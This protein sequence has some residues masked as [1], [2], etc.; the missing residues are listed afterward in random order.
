MINLEIPLEQDRHF[1]YRLFEILPGAL[2][3]LLLLMPFILS[4]INVSLAVIF[5]VAYLLIYFVR[6]LGIDIRAL[7]GY[8][9]MKQHQRLVW[10]QLLVELESG[11]I[12]EKVAIERPKWHFNNVSRLVINPTPVKP[13]EVIHVAMIATYNESLEVLEP[14]VQSLLASNYDPHQIILV[15]AYEE[16]GGERTEENVLTLMAK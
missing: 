1:R 16:R 10:K 6:S 12:D 15:F 14:T 3:W 7:Q 11:V 2:T 13:S 8:R 9:I 4:L 5:I